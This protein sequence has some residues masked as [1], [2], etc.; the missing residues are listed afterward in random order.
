MVSAVPAQ[1]VIPDL[2]KHPELASPLFPHRRPDLLW[3]QDE[4]TSPGTGRSQLKT[5]GMVGC[6][7]SV[8]IITSSPCR[9]VKHLAGRANYELFTVDCKYSLGNPFSNFSHAR[10]SDR[11]VFRC[12]APSPRGEDQLGIG[13]PINVRPDPLTCGCELFRQG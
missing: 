10:E 13:V 11:E 8:V 7:H 2:S 4:S 12:T 6:K 3:R 1:L 5:P 9:G